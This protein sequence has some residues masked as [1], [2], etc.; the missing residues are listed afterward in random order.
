MILYFFTTLVH[1]LE[2]H[3][4]DRT[5]LL[6]F[7]KDTSSRLKNESGAENTYLPKSLKTHWMPSLLSLLDLY[8]SQGASECTANLLEE[9]TIVRYGVNLADLDKY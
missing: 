1:L 3:T 2:A 6:I 4:I 5:R 9:G 8:F 7:D